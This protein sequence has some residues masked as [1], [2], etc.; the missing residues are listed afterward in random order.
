MILH[1]QCYFALSHMQLHIPPRA[2][3]KHSI[4]WADTNTLPE[5]SLVGVLFTMGE[6][7]T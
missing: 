2:L 1:V 4:L 7:V 3:Q 6:Q 5:I